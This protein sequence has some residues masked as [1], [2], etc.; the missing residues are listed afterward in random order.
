MSQ[1]IVAG[2]NMPGYMPD[3]EPAECDSFEQARDY[4]V[5]ELNSVIESLYTGVLG[6]KAA[7]EDERETALAEEQELTE[8][9]AYVKKQTGEFGFKAGKYHYFATAA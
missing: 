5:E 2:W 3:S 1:K 8:A 6:D 4:I 7:P 9:I